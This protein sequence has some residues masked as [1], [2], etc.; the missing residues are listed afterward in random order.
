L[1]N[2]SATVLGV[3]FVRRRLTFT[4]E[5]GIDIIDSLGRLPPKRFFGKGV[6]VVEKRPNP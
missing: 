3:N 1:D 4:A 2:P 6:K 5:V